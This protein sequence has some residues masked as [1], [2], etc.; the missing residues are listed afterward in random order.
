MTCLRQLSIW[1][2]QVYFISWTPRLKFQLIPPGRAATSWRSM[3]P[4]K[5]YDNFISVQNLILCGRNFL[6]SVIVGRKFISVQ[7]WILWRRNFIRSVFGGRKF[8]SEQNSILWRQK[9]SRKCYCSLQIVFC[10][11]IDSM[12]EK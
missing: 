1:N 11:E 3:E 2:F 4:P 8:I 7:S 9:F 12:R 6:R 10:A 5:L